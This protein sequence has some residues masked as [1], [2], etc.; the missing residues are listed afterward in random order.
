MIDQF[1]MSR[2]DLLL[3]AS[4]AYVSASFQA[5]GA[6]DMSAGDAI[7]KTYRTKLRSRRVQIQDTEIEIWEGG[8]GRTTFALTHPYLDSSGPYA[9][10]GFSQALAAAG[11]LIYVCPRGTGGS[12]PEARPDKLTMSQTVDDMEAVRKVLNIKAWVPCGVSTGGMVTLLYAMRYPRSI[13]G[14]IPACTADSY[15][16]TEDPGSLYNPGNEMAKD[17]AKIRATS[18]EKAAFDKTLY[19]SVHNKALYPGLREIL[20]TSPTR[21]AAI[22]KEVLTDKWDYAD[23]IS[24]ITA[25]T[26]LIAGRYDA[27]CGSLKPNFDI[28]NSIADSELAIMNHSGHF[29]FDEE[30]ERFAGA[31]LEFTRRRLDPIG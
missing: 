29:P 12:A 11:R 18:G 9:G 17:I 14:S 23:Q 28:V 3:L 1:S 4:A 21:V 15:H 10:C 5:H 26:L 6:T 24:K 7:L 25:P 2:R 8:S 22:G 13:S 30:P 16:W 20:K 27:Q 19:Y 31:V